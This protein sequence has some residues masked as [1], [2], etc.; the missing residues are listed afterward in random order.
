MERNRGLQDRYLELK[1][2]RSMCGAARM[3]R[4]RN[5]ELKRKVGVK[6]KLSDRVDRKVLKCFGYVERLGGED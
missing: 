2:I 3:D 5:E 1:S 6:E 4:G